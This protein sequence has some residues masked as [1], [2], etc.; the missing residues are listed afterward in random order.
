L[1]DI[2]EIESSRTMPGEKLADFLDQVAS[3]D[4]LVSLLMERGIHHRIESIMRDRHLAFGA[5][6]AGLKIVLTD[7]CP[8]GNTNTVQEFEEKLIMYQTRGFREVGR[9]DVIPTGELECRE[10]MAISVPGSDR[11]MSCGSADLESANIPRSLTLTLQ[12]DA[13]ERTNEELLDLVWRN[14]TFLTTDDPE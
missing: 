12:I 9:G 8:A 2:F 6:E 13:G 10:C 11:C 4:R 1:I 3:P 7:L 5:D 14:S